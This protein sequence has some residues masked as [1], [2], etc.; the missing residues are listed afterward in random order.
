M[1]LSLVPMAQGVKSHGFSVSD[2]QLVVFAPGNLQYSS[3]EGSHLCADG[4]KQP[5]LWRF[6]PSQWEYTL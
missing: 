5:G 3:S 1:L 6:A 2:D 4:T